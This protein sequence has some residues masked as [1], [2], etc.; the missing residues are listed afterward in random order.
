MCAKENRLQLEELIEIEDVLN[1]NMDS[2]INIFP[3]LLKSISSSKIKEIKN[4]DGKIM[5]DLN[6]YYDKL[7]SNVYDAISIS[8]E[9]HKKKMEEVS[10]QIASTNTELVS[11]ES[12]L[13]IQKILLTSEHIRSSESSLHSCILDIISQPTEK[14][15]EANLD[16]LLQ[17]KDS[18]SL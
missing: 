10:Q 9:N 7:V 15:I 17:I 3:A 11:K 16:N 18:Y 1:F 6:N 14:D 2:S 12:I 5:K 8:I 4:L 13:N